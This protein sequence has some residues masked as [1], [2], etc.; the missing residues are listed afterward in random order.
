MTKKIGVVHGRFQPLHLGHL[1]NY[2]MRAW[3]KCD[4]LVVGITNP[5]SMNSVPDDVNPSRTRLKNNP[6]NYFERYTIIERALLARGF[7]YDEFRIVPFPISI[8]VNL[9]FYVPRDAFNYL[10]IFDAWGVKKLEILKNHGFEAISIECDPKVI[11]AT[12]V[13]EAI[14]EGENWEGLV[15][16]STAELIVD[17]KLK[18]TLIKLA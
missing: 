5:D 2:I 10:T 14:L 7:R 18:E 6:L 12:L 13:R 9:Q 3:E 17:L 11:S 16:S 8:P 4:F 1:D 15:H